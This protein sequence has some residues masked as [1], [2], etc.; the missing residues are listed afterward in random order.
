MSKATTAKHAR[1][2]VGVA[3]FALTPVAQ[4][5]IEEIVV[6]AQKRESVLQDTPIAI[7]AFSEDSIERNQIEDFRDIAMRTP[8]L[9]FAQ[10]DGMSIIALRG[11]GLDITSLGGETAIAAYQDGVYLGQSF[12]L[13]MPSFDLERIEVLR[14][15]QGTLY[16]RNATGGAV[17]LIT[18]GPSFDNDANIALTYKDYDH[19]KVEAG[20]T[21]GLSDIVAIRGS[22]VYDDRQEGFRDQVAIGGETDGDESVTGNFSMLITP[23]EA[24]DITLR[25][26]ITEQETGYGTF[27]NL[28]FAP[29]GGTFISPANTGGFFNFPDPA[30]GGLS[31]ADVFGLNFPVATTGNTPTDEDDLDVAGEFRNKQEYDVW[32]TS[33]TVD[34]DVGNVTI[35]SITAYRDIEW[36]RLSDEDGTN[37]Q[38]LTLDGVQ[39]AETFTQEINISGTSFDDRLEWLVGGYYFDEDASAEFLYDLGDLQLFYEALIGLFSAGAPLAPGS[40]ETFSVGNPLALGIGRR[41]GENLPTPFLHFTMDQESE[42]I[43]AFGEAKYH[44]TDDFAVTAGARWTRDEK[45]VSRSLTSNF[46]ALLDPSGL[47]IDAP[48]DND[49]SEVTG[50]V[51]AEYALNDRSMVFGKVSRGYKAGGFNPGECAGGFDPETIYAYELGYKTQ[52]ADDQV[53]INSALFYYD[54]EDI[55]I[56][57]F[58]NN[59]SSVTNAAKAEIFG[60]ESEFVFA[61]QAA[62]GLLISGSIGYLDT[63]YDDATFADPIN[64][65]AA[66]DV[67]GN[68]LVRAPEWKFSLAAQYRFRV[69]NFGEIVLQADANHSD[70]YYFDVFEGEL[71]NQSEMEQDAYT[72]ANVRASWLADQG[73]YEVMLFVENVTDELY[74]ETRVAVG[75][76]GAVIGQFSAPRTWGIRFSAKFGAGR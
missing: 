21:G 25:A 65:G 41:Q 46:V 2:L 73:D 51:I 6:T 61:P 55:Q 44:V 26:N 22:V 35:K 15:P 12:T 63:E 8:G 16:G 50:N 28:Q 7:T 39:E 14:G 33:A 10:T 57:R 53:Q 47:C 71:F 59:A 30:L 13:S 23:S 5:V 37:L 38:L 62:E 42:S 72:I 43:A 52:F 20:A 76:T 60:F 66:I 74:A 40:F 69:E 18:R 68:N 64:G 70:S 58:I 36:K 45:D 29:T 49:W 54:Y 17:N 67:S 24:L 34:W 9:V 4:A 11:V 1:V 75:T 32:G 3:G 19:I 56:N 31:L 27:E 48:D